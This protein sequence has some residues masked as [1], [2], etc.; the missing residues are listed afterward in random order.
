MK[1]CTKGLTVIPPVQP[2]IGIG[3]AMLPLKTLLD[4]VTGPERGGVV[5]EASQLVQTQE[6]IAIPAPNNR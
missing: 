3:N 2:E 4:I 1:E 5:E 6:P